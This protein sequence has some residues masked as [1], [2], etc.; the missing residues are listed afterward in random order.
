MKITSK[1]AFSI[2]LILMQSSL[3]FA[4]CVCVTYPCNCEKWV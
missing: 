3:A 1:S 4:Y 2:A